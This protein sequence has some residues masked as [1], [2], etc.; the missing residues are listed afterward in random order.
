MQIKKLLV[1]LVALTVLPITACIGDKE[2]YTKADGTEVKVDR[3]LTET[4]VQYKK[5]GV[6][7]EKEYNKKGQLVEKD[8]YKDNH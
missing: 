2:S 1:G 8:V 5:N 6:E 4:N 3:D 7:V